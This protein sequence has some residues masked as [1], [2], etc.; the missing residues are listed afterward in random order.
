[1]TCSEC[2]S[3]CTKWNKCQDCDKLTVTEQMV[4]N[5][6]I[7]F[8]SVDNPEF[9]QPGITEYEKYYENFFTPIFYFYKPIHDGD[10]DFEL[11]RKQVKKNLKDPE[12]MKRFIAWKMK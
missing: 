10:T 12:F 2:N 7:L 9:H 3:P 1:M 8:D 5:Y 11:L 4:G 6:I